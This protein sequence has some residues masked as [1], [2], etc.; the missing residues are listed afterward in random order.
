MDGPPVIRTRG[1]TKRYGDHI[2]VDHLDLE[3]HRGEVFGLL[4]PNGAG[5][6]TTILMLLGLSEPS[7]GEAEVLGLDPTRQPLQVKQRV[8]YLPD[9]VGFYEQMSGRQNLRY[10]ARLNG[11]RDQEAEGRVQDLLEQ[12][13]LARAADL[14]VGAYSRGMRQRLGIADALVKD[15]EVVILDEPTIAI[16]PE[17]VV[18]VLALIRS[19][20]ERQGVTVLLSSHLL[21]QVQEVCDRVGIFVTGRLLTQGPVRELAQQLFTGVVTVEAGVDAEPQRVEEVLTGLPGVQQVQQDPRDPRL[22]LVTGSEDIAN[23]VARAVA[24]EG[25]PI[26]HLRRRGEELDE[27]YRRY[28]QEEEVARGRVG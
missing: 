6:T 24:A 26:R 17:G 12:A 7:E 13:R 23:Q 5:K 22:W 19:L 3:V 2:A 10:T 4:G 27:L 11:L 20:A 9:N 28:F 1:L 15:P 16:D 8:G 21:H 25:L 14:P 18:E